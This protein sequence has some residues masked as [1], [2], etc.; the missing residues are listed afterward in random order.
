M[1]IFEVNKIILLIIFFVPGFISMKIYPLLIATDKTNFKDAIM[2]AVGF[3]AINFASFSWLIILIHSN[4]FPKNHFTW[5]LIFCIF[6]IFI[7]PIFWTIIYVKIAKSKK[8]RKYILNPSKLPWDAYFE[9]KKSCWVVVNLKNGERIGGVYSDNSFASAYPHKEQI[10][11]QEQWLFDEK[12]N[13][14]KKRK[15]TNGVLILG[16]EIKT[17]EFYN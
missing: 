8:L 15:R 6:I 11:I 4:D 17:I 12:G 9:Q 13:F 2:E 10:Y 1:E 16:D 14:K 3:S 5:Y 7:M